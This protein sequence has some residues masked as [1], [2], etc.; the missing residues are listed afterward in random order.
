M[1]LATRL[2]D[3][4]TA[5]GTDIK[6]LRTYVTGSSTGDLTGLTTTAKSNLVAAINEIKASSGGGSS[7]MTPVAKNA[8]TTATANQIVIMTGNFAV[9]LPT[10]PADGTP[11]GVVALTTSVTI[12]RGGAADV[13]NREGETGKT[14]IV[15]TPGSH[16]VLMYL[17]GTW[18]VIN[19]SV[20]SSRP[21]AAKMYRAAAYTPPAAAYQYIP[22][23][24]TLYDPGNNIDLANQW[25][26]CPVAGY[27]QVNGEC[28]TGANSLNLVA[29]YKNG[30]N[31][32]EGNGTSWS[33]ASVS[34]IIQCAAGDKLK[35]AIYDNSG[36]ALVVTQG[37]VNN[38][39]SVSL[40]EAA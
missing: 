26:V 23:D 33:R 15:I 1:S 34:D 5:V 8:A 4:I 6:T 30:V 37:Q 14:A 2:S 20:R 12:N 11:V 38:Y 18:Y 17:G 7:S 28:L 25:Y 27:Y 40:L 3:L 19:S 9:T 29:I 35:L 22:F 16:I 21:T 36:L 32:S 31:V 10:A 39:M 13:I 24:T